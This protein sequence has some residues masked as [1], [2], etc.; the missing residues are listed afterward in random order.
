MTT[1][2]VGIYGAPGLIDSFFAEKDWGEVDA[3]VSELMAKHPGCRVS[4]EEDEGYHGESEGRDGF[5]FP[6]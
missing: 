6:D 1:F 4:V 5:E 3:Y 2:I